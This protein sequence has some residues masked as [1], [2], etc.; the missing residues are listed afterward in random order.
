MR[1][2]RRH[3]RRLSPPVKDRPHAGWSDRRNCCR[4][5]EAGGLSVRPFRAPA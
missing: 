5:H 3:S 1:R 2:F 4:R